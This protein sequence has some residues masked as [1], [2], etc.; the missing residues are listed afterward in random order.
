MTHDVFSLSLSPPPYF[1]QNK[2]AFHP[3]AAYGVSVVATRAQLLYLV[4]HYFMRNHL[5]IAL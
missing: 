3:F 1:Q 4:W 2:I 5:K